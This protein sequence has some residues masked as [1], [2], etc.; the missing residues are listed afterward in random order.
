[1]KVLI[2]SGIWP[3]DVGG[4]ASHA[5][6]LAERLLARGHDV[7]VM[8]TADAAPGAERY[9][10]RWVS[11]TEPRGVRHAR[12]AVAIARAARGADV[13][14]A[15][16]M[17]ARTSLAARLARTPVV[18]K[19]TSDPTY[20]R[21]L[22]YRL[23]G[24]GLDEFQSA[25]GA[26]VRVLRR[27]RD[28]TLRRAAHLVV[29]SDSLRRLAL[30]WGVEPERITLLPNPVSV[31]AELAPRDELRTRL[32]F[33]GFTLAFAGRFAPQKSLEVALDAVAAV[34][35]VSLVLAGD[36]PEEE[37][38]RAHVRALGLDAR[39]RFLGP[40]PRAEVFGLLRAADAALLSSSWENFP[41]MV[42]EALAVGTP[43]IATDVGGVAEIVRDGENG[44][45]VPAGDTRALA[46]AI[47]RVVADPA[48]R[49]RIASAAPLAA[50]AYAPDRIYGELERILE[51]A[52][53]A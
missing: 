8:I 3:P 1:V 41:H 15:T 48:L 31:P 33:D 38:L 14:Y 32:A 24:D 17:L 37:R 11:R 34:E 40:L 21:S 45:L 13:V 30:G 49:D 7:E 20:E 47:A 5:P 36:G 42:V 29:P 12:A 44:L 50:E 52:A 39:V 2:V 19:L 6:E 53:R 28:L 43:V 4:P 22:R 18:M 9:P 51:R 46:D 10:V 23:T 35:G 16:G 26:R 25:R 27:V